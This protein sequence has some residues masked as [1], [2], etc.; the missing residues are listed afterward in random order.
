M[1]SQCARDL[2]VIL[3]FV[4]FQVWSIRETFQW[5]FGFGSRENESKKESLTETRTVNPPTTQMSNVHRDVYVSTQHSTGP[6]TDSSTAQAF[7]VLN[8]TRV[9]TP[10]FPLLLPVDT[11]KKRVSCAFRCENSSLSARTKP[12]ST[13]IVASRRQTMIA[14]PYRAQR[15]LLARANRNLRADVARLEANVKMQERAKFSAVSCAKRMT[16]R[17]QTEQNRNKKELFMIQRRFRVA[18]DSL[19]RKWMSRVNRVLE[20]DRDDQ[21]SVKQLRSR[22]SEL[23]QHFGS[24]SSAQSLVELEARIAEVRA[25]CCDMHAR[26]DE[27]RFRGQ[28]D[29]PDPGPSFNAF[30]MAAGFAN[31]ARALL[32]ERKSHMML[33][34]M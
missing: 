7:K 19:E 20:D 21:A 29:A 8:T 31:G 10:S 27:I 16:T 18:R 17:E 22:V 15:I 14:S 32:F 5:V 6:S 2:C 25:R 26:L 11:S 34:A 30:A 9:A 28:D 1:D 12:K 33:C 24:S 13:P 3:L 23:E 4:Y